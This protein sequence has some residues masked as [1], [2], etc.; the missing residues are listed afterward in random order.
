MTTRLDVTFA[1]KW[2]ILGVFLSCAA[3]GAGCDHTGAAGPGDPPLPRG[4]AVFSRA[5]PG[6][7]ETVL[8]APD[9][10]LSAAQAALFVAGL[11]HQS[12][13]GQCPQIITEG[14]TQVTVI[15]E[16]CMLPSGG[17]Y[18]GTAR[19]TA[20]APGSRLLS[21]RFDDFRRSEASS[22]SLRMD[23]SAVFTRTGEQDGVSTIRYATMLALAFYRHARPDA[24]DDRKNVEAELVLS[25]VCRSSMLDMLTCELET[26]SWVNLA[27]VGRFDIEGSYDWNVGAI[28]TPRISGTLVFH[29]LEVLRAEYPSQE[30][31][32]VQ[33]TIGDSAPE[34]L[35]TRL[36]GVLARVAPGA[37]GPDR[38]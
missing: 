28:G 10:A 23:G 32:C 21:T 27:G 36:G 29:G 2:G 24:G 34:T 31:Q 12:S 11:D 16:G 35:C 6:Q 18:Q 3:I 33:Y 13:G 26:G 9:L 38:V 1:R 8:A 30:G 25:A 15:G 4:T 22:L 14:D 17:S 19:Y 5:T 7:L 37:A 20:L